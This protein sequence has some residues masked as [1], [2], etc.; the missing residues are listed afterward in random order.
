[1]R[2]VKLDSSQRKLSFSTP[3]SKNRTCTD[4][5]KKMDDGEGADSTC[6]KEEKSGGGHER[7]FQLNWLKL[8][9]WLEFRDGRMF[10][11]VCLKHGKKNTMTAGC[12]TFKTSTMMRHEQ[13]TDHQAGELKSHFDA[14]VAKA[15]SEEDEGVIKALKVVYWLASENLPM[16]KYESLMQLLKELEVPKIHCLSQ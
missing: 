5:G 12:T 7:K 3:G 16:S 14:A 9:E 2:L 1:M 10:C 15:N 11:K 13:F 6:S 8:W 4:A